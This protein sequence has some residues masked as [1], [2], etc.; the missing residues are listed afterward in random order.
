MTKCLHCQTEIEPVRFKIHPKI[1]ATYEQVL[2]TFESIPENPNDLPRSR[3]RRRAEKTAA[4]LGMSRAAVE[5][6]LRLKYDKVGG[7]PK[8]YCSVECR[9]AAG[10]NRQMKRGESQ[11]KEWRLNRHGKMVKRQKITCQICG[12][13]SIRGDGNTCKSKKCCNAIS[14]KNATK[15]YWSNKKKELT[16]QGYK[17]NKEGYITNL[18]CK[19]CDKT[20]SSKNNCDVDTYKPK[21]KRYENGWTDKRDRKLLIHAYCSGECEYQQFLVDTMDR[22]RKEGG[23]KPRKIECPICSEK[24]ETYK[25]NQITCGDKACQKEFASRQGKEMR[26]SHRATGFECIWCKETFISTTSWTHPKYCSEKCADERKAHQVHQEVVNLDDN[27]LI[28]L[29]KRDFIKYEDMKVSEEEISP[30]MIEDKKLLL[31]AKRAWKSVTGRKCSAH[32][33]SKP[34][35]RPKRKK[36]T[37]PRKA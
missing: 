12:H 34:V 20:F 10:Q 31:Q 37:Q 29:I 35:G 27:Y 33:Y 15:S 21:D 25:P 11:G 2:K 18:T 14:L 9:S 32:V 24:S 5:R 23:L 16:R 26:D 8:K 7:T 13:E 36:P 19:F 1:K 30:Q 22:R 28:Q 17:I 4:L 3:N 6:K